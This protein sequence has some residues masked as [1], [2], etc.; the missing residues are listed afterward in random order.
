MDPI[1][2]SPQEIA[3]ILNDVNRIAVVGASADPSKASYQVI[4]A[5]LAEGYEVVSVNP[6]TSETSILNTPV[7][8]SLAAV[9]QKIDMVDVFRPSNEL[10]QITEQA[11][12]IGA[13][14]VW[15]QLGIV[16]KQAAEL[17]QSAGLRVVM[18]RCPKI[19][20]A[21]ADVRRFM[22]QLKQQDQ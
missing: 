11:I 14:V 15:A 2:D 18:N 13:Q 4:E 22:S 8:S 17:A 16:D 19:E 12:A 10:Y 9:E 6:F 7:Y 1:N 5:L 3:R 21:R 20:F